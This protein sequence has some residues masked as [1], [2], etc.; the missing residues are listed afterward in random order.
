MSIV[1]RFPDYEFR[2]TVVPSIVDRKDIEEIGKWLK[3]IKK[4]ALQQFQNKK[5]LS[6]A[7]K[8]IKPYSD[9]IIKDFQKILKKYIKDVEVRS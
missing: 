1:T 2:T 7:F 8:K 4:F 5:V 3:G 6:P 9:E